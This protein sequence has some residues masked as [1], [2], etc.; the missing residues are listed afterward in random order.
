MTIYNRHG[1]NLMHAT[2]DMDVKFVSYHWINKIIWVLF[3]LVIWLPLTK[4]VTYRADPIFI[5]NLYFYVDF[6]FYVSITTHEDIYW[7]ITLVN[8]RHMKRKLMA[9]IQN[10]K[11]NSKIMKNAML[12]LETLSSTMTKAILIFF[13]SNIFKTPISLIF[14]KKIILIIWTIS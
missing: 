14:Y 10:L 5:L 1:T 4:P 9:W 6:N 12:F 13:T 11:K 3:L 2:I 7:K 8:F